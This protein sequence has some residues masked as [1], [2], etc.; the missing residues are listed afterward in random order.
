MTACVVMKTDSVSIAIP[1]YEISAD[2]IVDLC[3]LKTRSQLAYWWKSSTWKTKTSH[4]TRK[5]I[6]MQIYA[7]LKRGRH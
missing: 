5:L 3:S 7:A 6:E 2:T 1:V 4:A